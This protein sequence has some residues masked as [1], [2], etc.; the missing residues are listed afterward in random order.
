MKLLKKCR[1]TLRKVSPHFPKSG[2]TSLTDSALRGSFWISAQWLLNKAFTAG[3]MLL[4]AYFLSPDEYGTAATVLAI[5]SFV[6]ILRP[7]VM[8]DVLIAYPRH[9]RLLAPTARR[10]VLWVGAI[11]TLTT[12]IA[13]PVVLQ[14][15]ETYPAAW[16]AGLL[17]AL[18]IS[19]LLE[20][21]SV[22][23]VSN[24]RQKLEFR[25]IAILDGVLQL[26][27][28]LFSVG[29]AAGGGRA[30]ALILPQILR[31]AVSAACYVRIGSVRSARRFHRRI[32]RLLIRPYLTAV[33]AQYVHNIVMQL[34]I[35][36][37]GYLVG[38]YQTGL[39]GFAFML[40]VQAN[41][42]ITGQLG[43]VLQPLLGRLQVDPARQIQGFLRSQQ[44]LGMLCVPLA[45]LQIVLA[46]PF[47]PFIVASEVAAGHSDLPVVEP[48]ASLLLCVWAEHGVS[49]VATSL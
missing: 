4:I 34:E 11:S 2:E 32:A 13:I 30:A 36:V 19:P 9:L 25:R 39:F 21:I 24:L 15:Y 16:L 35:V 6:W 10:L 3:A 20:A 17:A 14:V 1:D 37:L 29:L 43:F 49:E 42:I 38:A 31:Q 27:A 28:T 45:L 8:G 41:T 5:A 12:L 23:P 18:A 44:I 40:A 47:L 48:D 33:G 22:V 26:A 46:E 7:Q